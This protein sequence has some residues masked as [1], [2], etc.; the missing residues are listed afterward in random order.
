MVSS[1][2]AFPWPAIGGFVSGVGTLALIAYL[3]RHRGKPGANW[4][5]VA[6][7]SQALWCFSYTAS[8][9]VRDEGVRRAFESVTWVG[10]V[11]LG[12]LFLLFALEYTGRGDLIHTWSVRAMGA[13]PAVSTVLVVTNRYH[14]LVWTDFH[15]DPA[16]GL[17]TVGYTF[18]PV[19][20]VVAGFA[21][22]AATVAFLLLAETIFSYG[23]LYRGEAAVV[24]LSAVPPAVAFLAWLFELGP[25]PQVQWAVIAFVPHVLLDAYA[26]VGNDMFE[27]NPTTRRAAERRAVDSIESPFLVLDPEDRVVDFNGAAASLFDVDT[28]SLGEPVESVLDVDPAGADQSVTVRSDGQRREFAVSISELTDP[29]GVH[30]GATVLLQDVTRRKRREQRL[31]VLNRV[32]RHNLRNGV[33]VIEGHAGNIEAAADDPPIERSAEVIVSESQELVAIGEK[34]RRFERTVRD[35][36]DYAAVDVESPVAEVTAEVGDWY[37]DAHIETHVTDH[38]AI[39]SDPELLRLIVRNLVENAVEHNDSAEPWAEVSVPSIDPERRGLLIEVSDDGPGIHEDEL[40]PFR[41]GQE[42]ALEHG[43]GIGLWVVRWCVAVLG[44]DIDVETGDG[45]T[46]SVRI[47]VERAGERPSPAV[48]GE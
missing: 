3:Y 9:F 36:P 27:S 29:R 37:P 22:L 5:I 41:V 32:L 26:F 45:T 1:V 12:F 13:V 4:F 6:L 19:A 7:G 48:E 39:R 25:Y 46:V 33:T 28:D 40:A 38:P 42:D 14:G 8:L 31:E 17:A 11:W 21:L 30:V 18:G 44:G 20:Y 16:F 10:V 35:A 23:P 2:A 15:F 43:S 34:A 24:A 47:P